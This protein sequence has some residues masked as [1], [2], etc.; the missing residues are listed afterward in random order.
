MSL[1]RALLLRHRALTLLVL[2]AAL[3][4][5][6]VVPAGYMLD[7]NAGA[8]TVRLCN[9]ASGS[10]APQAITIPMKPDA[11]DH[12][13]DPTGHKATPA[14]PYAALTLATLGGADPV[15]L[16]LALAFIV[17]LGFVPTVGP[18]TQRPTHLRPPLRAPPAHV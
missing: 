16:G 1:L 13:D 9:D 15:L 7:G 11:G 18:R 14:C 3:C 2:A 4:L 8:I 12:P 6:A 5:K 10:A 17:L